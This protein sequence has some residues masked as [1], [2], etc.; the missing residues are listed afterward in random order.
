[1]TLGNIRLTARSIGTRTQRSYF[2]PDPI[3]VVAQEEELAVLLL[4]IC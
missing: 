3:S 1:M 2:K 4:S